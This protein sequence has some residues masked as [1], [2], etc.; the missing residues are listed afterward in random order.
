M[1][2]L[3]IKKGRRPAFIWDKDNEMVNLGTVGRYRGEARIIN[4]EGLVAGVFHDG[5]NQMALIARAEAK[6]IAKIAEI[7]ADF[8]CGFHVNQKNE[9]ILMIKR[10]EGL[11]PFIRPES[12]EITGGGRIHKDDV[13]SSFKRSLLSTR[14]SWD[15]FL[16]SEEGGLIDLDELVR[17]R[18]GWVKVSKVTGINNKGQI[19]GVGETRGR[20]SKAFI[21]TPKE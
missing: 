21:L 3:Y 2:Q 8:G 12:P 7:E 11:V 16:W 17:S 18:T 20:Q 5:K 6:S 19:I 13:L 4:N 9:V 10:E 14:T 1:G 15:H